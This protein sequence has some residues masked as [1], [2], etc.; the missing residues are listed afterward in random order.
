VTEIK[1]FEIKC[2]AEVSK[3]IIDLEELNIELK[4]ITENIKNAN[5]LDL[6]RLKIQFSNFISWHNEV[7]LAKSQGL[8]V[9]YNEYFLFSM[10]SEIRKNFRFILENRYITESVEFYL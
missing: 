2:Q 8:D 10:I 3:K 6:F 4:I 1:D 9:Y 7:R 5:L